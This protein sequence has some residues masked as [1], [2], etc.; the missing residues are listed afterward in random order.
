LSRVKQC[1]R[2]RQFDNYPRLLNLT[3]PFKSSKSGQCFVPIQGAVYNTLDVQRHIGRTAPRERVLCSF[4]WQI[5]YRDCSRPQPIRGMESSW[6]E[7]PHQQSPQAPATLGQ[8]LLSM[9]LSGNDLDNVTRTI[10]GEAGPSATPASIAA[11]ASVIR[12]RLAAGGYGR[13]PTE[14]VHGIDRAEMLSGVTEP[15]FSR[16]ST[17]C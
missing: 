16:V 5:A 17:R 13:S 8:L 1:R 4:L 12:N 10:L 3:T 6:R 11:V 14:I 7:R 15:D 9:D 2:R